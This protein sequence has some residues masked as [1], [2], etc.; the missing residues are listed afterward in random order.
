[1]T[2][3]NTL[4]GSIEEGQYLIE[5]INKVNKVNK[6]EV[7]SICTQTVDSKCNHLCRIDDKFIN[8][9]GDYIIHNY[10]DL[11]TADDIEHMS[12]FIINKTIK[13]VV[14]YYDTENT[15]KCHIY[16]NN[17][18]NY[19]I[20]R[21]VSASEVYSKYWTYLS[22]ED[23]YI[24]K[25]YAS[26]EELLNYHSE[27]III[28][29]KKRISIKLDNYFDP[30]FF[31]LVITMFGTLIF[32]VITQTLLCEMLLISEIIIIGIFCYIK[33][34]EPKWLIKLVS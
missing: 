9:T 1:M 20:E 15:Y 30:L 11:I 21:R 18:S 12:K 5:K 16:Y 34:R 23:K 24:I 26:N 22:T 14:I 6:I 25:D 19:V 28:N 13:K 31:I 33:Y 29:N 17:L 2:K 8:L 32:F 4:L 27:F 10:Y 3:C 7:S